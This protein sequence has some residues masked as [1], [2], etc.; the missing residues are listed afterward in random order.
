[1]KP[2]PTAPR[3]IDEYIAG[4]PDDVQK[5]LHKIRRTIRKAAPG[6]KEAISYQIPAFVQNGTLI[7]F[8]GYKQHVGVYPVPRGDA[9]FQKDVAPYFVPKSTVRLPLDAPIPYDLVRRMVEF[10]LREMPAA[11]ARKKKSE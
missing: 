4:F 5:V 6:A 8:A 2:K 7:Y 11:K 1:M 10:R 9:Q 3:D